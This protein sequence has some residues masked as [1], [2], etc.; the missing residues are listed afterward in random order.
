VPNYKPVA[1]TEVARQRREL[2]QLIGRAEAVQEL[3]LR[4]DLAKFACTRVTGFLEQA[5]LTMGIDLIRR[6]SS[7]V[8]QTFALSHLDRS[9]NPASEAILLFVGRF[10][11]TWRAELE[12]LLREDE[13]AQTLNALV[14]ARNQIAH[15]K[16]Q[17]IDIRRV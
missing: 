4:A 10:H 6:L 7:G 14:G 5:L 1:R 16:N 3:D 11:P 17:G 9:F 2:D 13:Q 12:E 15:G 8:P